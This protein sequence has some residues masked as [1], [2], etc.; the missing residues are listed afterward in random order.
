MRY[1]KIGFYLLKCIGILFTGVFAGTLLLAMVFLLPVNQNNYENSK[2]VIDREGFYPLVPY[3]SDGAE[4]GSNF[5]GGLDNSSDKIMITTAMSVTESNALV[6][7]MKMYSEYVGSY[8][9]YW[10]GYVCILRP[11][12]LIFDYGELRSVNAIMQVLCMIVF[13]VTVADKLGKR[14]LL[15]VLSGYSFLMPLTLMFSFQYSWVF[16]IATL[17]SLFIITKHDY[18][19]KDGKI[20]FL[21][22]ISGML[23]SYMDL[24]TYPLITWG[25]PIIWWVLMSGDKKIKNN[26]LNVVFSG[27]SWIFGYAGMW[28]LKWEIGGFVLHTDLWSEALDEVFFRVGANEGATINTCIDAITINWKHYSYSVFMIIGLLWLSVLIVMSI[29]KGLM[30]DGRIPALI[31]IFISPIVWYSVLN[32]H[33]KIHHFFTYRIWNIGIYAAMAC[34]ML[35]ISSN[36]KSKFKERIFISFI[37]GIIVVA[38]FFPSG[39]IFGTDIKMNGGGERTFVK[40]EEG[41]P[42]TTGFTPQN[43]HLISVSL[44]VRTESECGHFLVTICD[45]NGTIIEKKKIEMD[46]VSDE[47]FTFETD[48][49][50]NSDEVYTFSIE[51]VG[52]EGE[53]FIEIKNGDNYLKEFGTN[54]ELGTEE[55]EGQ[56][57]STL[58]Y[59]ILEKNSGKELFFKWIST[60]EAG[61]MVF[62]GISQFL[63]LHYSKKKAKI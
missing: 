27:I 40:L 23:T 48:W 62:I 1:R 26:I 42:L 39:K 13:S 34:V 17:V 4:F 33:T 31:L 10:H 41:V 45:D 24:L 59:K 63:I 47:A 28:M 18:L 14:Y 55:Y 46:N 6:S 61:A 52:G 60:I 25:M 3:L 22:I 43:E 53:S 2:E 32:N 20:Y 9:Y 36:R 51:A 57:V 49:H 58:K 19:E 7:A 29:F 21:F 8:S 37:W 50:L 35:Y 16:Y 38:A 12:F 30:A 44:N 54:V 15:L 5:P 56:P 11:L